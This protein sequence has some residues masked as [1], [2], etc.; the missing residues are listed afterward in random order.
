LARSAPVSGVVS[1]QPLL[2]CCPHTCMTVCR[3]RTC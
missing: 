3:C 1:Q 2:R